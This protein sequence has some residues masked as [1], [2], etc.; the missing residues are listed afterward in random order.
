MKKLKSL[1]KIFINGKFIG[2]TYKPFLLEKLFKT[3]YWDYSNN[4]F[5][6]NG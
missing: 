3:K 4:K 5:N 1:T 2:G 6:I